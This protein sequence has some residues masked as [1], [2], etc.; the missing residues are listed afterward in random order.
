MH[1]V[2]CFAAEVST[3]S[4]TYPRALLSSVI[5]ITLC[6]VIPLG[7]AVA[8][9]KPDWTT[10]GDGSFATIAKSVGGEWLMWLILVGT[11]FGNAALFLAEGAKRAVCVCVCVCV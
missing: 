7:A 10:W 8:V 5:L 4:T 6:Y 1:Q 9:D 2:S 11:V 3:P